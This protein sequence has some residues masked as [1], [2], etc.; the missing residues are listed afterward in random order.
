MSPLSPIKYVCYI[1]TKID[2]NLYRV[3]DL[4]NLNSFDLMIALVANKSFM[5]PKFKKALLANFNL[6]I[7]LVT[8]NLLVTSTKY[9][10]NI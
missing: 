8:N 6:M 10:K 7:V 2:S 5:R 9:V 1:N 4:A 3:D